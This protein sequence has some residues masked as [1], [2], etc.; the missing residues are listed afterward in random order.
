MLEDAR[1]RLF[2]DFLASAAQGMLVS[3]QVSRPSVMLNRRR[4]QDTCIFNFPLK[5]LDD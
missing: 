4:Q 3:Y 5:I 2:R 1:E